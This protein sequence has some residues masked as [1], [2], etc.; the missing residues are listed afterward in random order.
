MNT[1]ECVSLNISSLGTTVLFLTM[2]LN[3][4]KSY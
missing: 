3:R 2:L 1:L 4:N